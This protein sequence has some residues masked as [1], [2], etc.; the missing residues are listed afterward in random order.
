MFL[1]SLYTSPSTL[2]N[3]PSLI[4]AIFL[5]S[6][7]YF[8]P[9]AKA[10]KLVD[11]F[12]HRALSAIATGLNGND[13]IPDLAQA[14]CLVSSFFYTSGRIQEG[15]YHA[16]AAVQLAQSIYMY[17]KLRIGDIL[18]Y[19][20]EARRGKMDNF[21]TLCQVFATDKGWSVATGLPCASASD[22]SWIMF[23]S[24]DL[25]IVRLWILLATATNSCPI[26]SAF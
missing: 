2:Q 10:P 21:S 4:N 6:S 26:L 5:L 22:D 23:D 20:L 7:R 16:T 12:L 8:P 9:I 13:Q 11:L 15:Y 17:T 14:S 18:P 24:H 1:S 25:T 19:S 3:R